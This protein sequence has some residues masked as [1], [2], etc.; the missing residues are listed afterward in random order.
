MQKHRDDEKIIKTADILNQN[1]E[2]QENTEK[3]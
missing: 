1:E 3:K 2:Q